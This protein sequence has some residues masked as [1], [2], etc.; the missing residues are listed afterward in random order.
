MWAW[1]DGSSGALGSGSAG[2]TSSASSRRR[3]PLPIAVREDAM[4]AAIVQVSVGDGHCL[5]CDELGSAYSWGRTREGQCG[6][7]AIAPVLQPQLMTDLLHE[8]VTQVACGTDASFALTAA[9]TVYEW[10][11]VH[12]PSTQLAHADLAGYGRSV[13]SLGES[14]RLM[15]QRSVSDFLS[16]RDGLEEGG[17]TADGGDEAAAAEA[18]ASDPTVG[19]KRELRPS[20]E[21]V[22]LPRGE[23]ASSVAA[24]FGFAVITLSGG[25]ARAFGTND[26]FQL[27]LHDRVPRDVPTRIPELNRL[28]LV[29]VA[30]GQQHAVVVDESGRAWSWGLGS[31]GQLGHGRRNDERSPRRVEALAEVGRLT[32][33]ACGQLHTAFLLRPAPGEPARLLGCGHAEYGQL[34]T[35]DAGSEGD[36]ARDYP[37]PRWIELPLESAEPCAVSCG[38]LHTCVLTTRG[39]C[40][41]FGWG[42]TG[43]LGHGTFGYQLTARQVEALR[44]RYLVGV[45]AGSRH[46]I[47]VE[48][49]A[50]GGASLS[51]D[52]GSLLRSGADADC[53]ILAGKE[54]GARRFLAHSGVLAC[55]CPRL[56]AMLA[57]GSS[58]FS[59]PPTTAPLAPEWQWGGGVIGGG[60]GG[61]GGGSGPAVPVPQAMAELRLPRVRAPIFA[62]LLSWLYTGQFHSTERLFLEQLA[63]AATALWL[64]ALAQ[65][66]H[67]LCAADEGQ[68]PSASASVSASAPAP[69]PVP[70]AALSASVS[71][72]LARFLEPGS[73]AHSCC[74]LQLRATDGVL[75][76]CRALLCCRSDFFRTLLQ[77]G[78]REGQ[79]D[80]AEERIIDLTAYSISL[81]ELHL[82]L[83]FIYSGRV[84]SADHGGAGDGG[85]LTN[86]AASDALALIPHAAALL[87]DDL[88]RLCEAVLVTVVD[89]ENAGALL[90]VAERCFAARLK[91]TC[92][93]VIAATSQIGHLLTG[94]IH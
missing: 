45:A 91:A 34:G 80:A 48:R 18:V 88:K 30:C 24:G 16:G 42:S 82:L 94:Q 64:P 31:F 54:P 4:Q 40:L 39:E 53:S 83:R 17:Q 36:A 93:D 49:G 7:L 2:S 70:A 33:V 3:E 57:F 51:R 62:L 9:G 60:G 8:W 25:G 27:G 15:L 23:R 66:C 21:R 78:F 72:G 41:T 5:A 46:T 85:D 35:G 13:D 90:D 76:A 47:A 20:P 63:T 10:G 56:L 14:T 50:T 58:R 73:L 44:A 65:E 26:R 22:S 37:L 6:S 67:A 84:T 87:M 52:L 59:R 29:G 19:T 86:M 55:R 81:A 43:A 74:D 92:S 28:R 69:A 89:E 61:G 79:Q 68:P 32:M 77:G 71:D 12:I 1:G 75:R 38:G 11:T